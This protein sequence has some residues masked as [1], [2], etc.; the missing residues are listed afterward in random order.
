MTNS[1]NGGQTD[2]LKYGQKKQILLE[3][4]QAVPL[5]E[6]ADQYRTDVRTIQRARQWALKRP[7]FRSS[8]D[9]KVQDYL[10]GWEQARPKKPVTP[11]NVPLEN[12]TNQVTLTDKNHI[13]EKSSKAIIHAQYLEDHYKDLSTTALSIADLIYGVGNDIGEQTIRQIVDKIGTWQG[14][15]DPPAGRFEQFHELSDLL[16][17]IEAK[18]LLSHIKYEAPALFIHYMYTRPKFLKYVPYKKPKSKN[19]DRWEEM[20]QDD[21]SAY[22]EKLIDLLKLRAG[23]LDFQGTC[24]YCEGRK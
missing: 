9:Q 24:E 3:L 2:R 18:W 8:L 23:R 21:V 15:G 12:V 6:I 19:I 14:G 1:S 4:S 13:E 10:T 11:P 22:G 7:G 20:T 16:S 5:K 17:S